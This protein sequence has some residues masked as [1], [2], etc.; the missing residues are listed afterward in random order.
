MLV[1]QYDREYFSRKTLIFSDVNH[2]LLSWLEEIIEEN[3]CRIDKKEWKSR[4][5][6]YVVYEYEPFCPEGFS[7]NLL[8]SSNSYEHISFVKYLYDTKIQV[9]QY[10]ER[11]LE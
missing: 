3:N 5:N 1:E 6:N 4:Y 9:M 2:N 8:I 7:I 10:L 11:C